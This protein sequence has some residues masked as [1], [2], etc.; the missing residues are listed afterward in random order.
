MSP[1][2]SLR[3]WVTYTS[4]RHVVGWAY[5]EDTVTL[6]YALF[7]G[8]IRCFCCFIDFLCFFYKFVY[9]VLD[10]RVLF[11]LVN[12]T[13]WQKYFFCNLICLFCIRFPCS[14]LVKINCLNNQIKESTFFSIGQNKKC[15][16]NFMSKIRSK[17]LDV[18]VSCHNNNRKST[19]NIPF[20][21]FY[22]WITQF[23]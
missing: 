9:V 2:S 6:V 7:T 8:F 23:V 3:K 21:N 18:H 22:V 4:T 11:Y 15:N 17:R 16:L 20:S 12:V 13:F 19:N 5:A 14:Y 10:Q 1:R